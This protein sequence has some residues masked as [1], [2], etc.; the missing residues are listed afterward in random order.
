MAKKTKKAKTPKAPKGRGGNGGGKD[1]VTGLSL[2]VPVDGIATTY[3]SDKVYTSLLP[4]I[5]SSDF[6]TLT[7]EY[8]LSDKAIVFTDTITGPNGVAGEHT[9][10]MLEGKFAYRNG[11]L[12]S[13]RID[14]AAGY[15]TYIEDGAKISGFA[16]LLEY[17]PSRTSTGPTFSSSVAELLVPDS[18]GANTLVDIVMGQWSLGERMIGSISTINNYYNGRIFNE[19]WWQDPFTPN[20]I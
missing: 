2:T 10:G 1:P 20:L 12:L 13:A 3:E 18:P 19:G 9:R 7:R 15:Q 11:K 4:I 16:T 5:G 17:I 14:R 6:N 8:E